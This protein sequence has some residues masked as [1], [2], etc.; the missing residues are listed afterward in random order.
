MGSSLYR[1]FGNE[2]AAGYER[3][4][5]WTIFGDFI[6]AHATVEISEKEIFVKFHKRAHNPLLLKAGFEKMRPA[7]PWLENK[8]TE[9]GLGVNFTEQG[10]SVSPG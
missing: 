4:K 2:I 9:S 3:A 6:D 8:K 1:L 10:R 7:I 5:S